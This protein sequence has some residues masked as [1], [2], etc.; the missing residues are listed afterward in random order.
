MANI[1]LQIPSKMWVKR[2]TIDYWLQWK[3][4]VITM[5][6]RIDVILKLKKKST[7]SFSSFNNFL[8]QYLKDS[9]P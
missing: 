3:T 2:N 8:Y 7:C 5:E 6:T 4:D 9:N 1:K